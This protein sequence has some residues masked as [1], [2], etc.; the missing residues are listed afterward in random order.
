MR[1][2]QRRRGLFRLT[3]ACARSGPGARSV[4]ARSSAGS[5]RGSERLPRG[6]RVFLES[7]LPPLLSRL[8]RLEERLPPLSPGCTEEPGTVSQS[9]SSC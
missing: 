6:G 8:T 4:C 3:P 1:D 5:Q 2:A 7:Q 9:A